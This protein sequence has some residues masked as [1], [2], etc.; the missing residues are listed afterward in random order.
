MPTFEQSIE[1]EAT[2]AEL[3][4]LTQDY[5]RRLEWDPFLKIAEL[6]GDAPGVGVRAWCVAKNGLGMETEYVSFNPPKGVAV[7]MTK[8]PFM[9][10]SFAGSWRFQEVAPGRTRVIFRYHLAAAP[11]W[12]GFI[13]DP[14]MR[15][16]F[17][18]DVGKR[19][20]GLKQSVETSDIL[21][22]P[23]AHS[24]GEAQAT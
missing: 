7:K 9:L 17:T 1:I 3:F 20:A 21:R 8:G 18:H 4:E 12:L 15:R 23:A 6:H 22:R 5:N 14:I 2:P 13:L 19:L 16:V 10:A 24:V 11:R